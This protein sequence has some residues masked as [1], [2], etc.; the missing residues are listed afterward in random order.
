MHKQ[1]SNI[2]NPIRSKRIAVPIMIYRLFKD[3]STSFGICVVV[4]EYEEEVWPE[5][6]ELIVLSCVI[7]VGVSIEEVVFWFWVVV[8]SW[9]DVVTGSD[10]DSVEVSPVD[11]VLRSSVVVLSWSDVE[12]GSDEDSVIVVL[13]SSLVVLSQS[14]VVSASDEDSVDISL[15]V[16]SSSDFVVESSV[17]ELVDVVI[18]SVVVS[19][20]QISSWHSSFWIEGLIIWRCSTANVLS[21]FMLASIWICKYK[22]LIIVTRFRF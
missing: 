16:V 12:S 4:S 1:H 11:V 3:F 21:P 13:R 5:D 14:V 17:L 9:S 22:R 15:I 18:G 6:V 2:N 10:E 7:L 8:L 19:E 20:C